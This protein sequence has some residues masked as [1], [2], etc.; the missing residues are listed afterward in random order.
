[1][2]N[3]GGKGGQV[4]FLNRPTRRLVCVRTRTGRPP[5]RETGSGTLSKHPQ[6][7]DLKS[8]ERAHLREAFSGEGVVE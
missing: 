5:E 8:L 6:L 3:R 4:P 2:E 1:M 7:A